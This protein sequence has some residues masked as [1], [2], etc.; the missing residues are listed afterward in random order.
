MPHTQGLN[1]VKPLEAQVP[2]L[3]TARVSASP[4]RVT[5]CQPGLPKY[6]IPI[7]T[8]L[9]AR[10]GIDLQVLYT[11]VKNLKNAVPQTFKAEHFDQ[12]VHV[13]AGRDIVW[14]S[15]HFAAATLEKSDVLIVPWNI[16]HL[17]LLP[18]LAK[19]RMMGVGTVLW[20]HGVSKSDNLLR[21]TIRWR[22]G[23][24]ADAV[25]F[26]NNIGAGKFLEFETKRER[27]FVAQNA[28]DQTA[29]QSERRALLKNPERLTAFAREKG[30][31]E[32][33]LIFVS[34]LFEDN[35]V[36]V[37]LRAVKRL[38]EHFPAIT[39]VIV[40]NGPAEESLRGL[41]TELGISDNVLF[42]GAVYEERDLAPFFLS[43]DL[44]V[45]PTN[46][47]LSILHAFGYGV[48]VVAG[49]LL[50]AH[51]P[52]IEAL[53]PGHNGIVFRHLDDAD[54]A[55][56]ILDLI[57]NPARLVSMSLFAHETATQR[58][59][60]K[61]MVDGIEAAIRFAALKARSRR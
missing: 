13:V 38:K 8:E 40:G 45:Y 30:L 52:E 35:R 21:R 4:I 20:G 28:L 24:M 44:F 14:H 43:A 10:P 25:M 50:H 54:M 41:V 15:E 46:L 60:V 49:D 36:D 29:I 12:K 53:E 3:Q 22:V 37:L 11:T 7:F 26:Y 48:P 55:Q 59:T 6:R 18:T 58:F 32:P 16:G 39:A 1:P 31:G 47:G 2:Q 23:R 56:Q 42:A 34:R 57:K 61:R 27:V 17:S 5:I 9:A 19:A 51:N 33:N